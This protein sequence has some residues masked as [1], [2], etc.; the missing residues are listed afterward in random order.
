MSSVFLQG[1]VQCLQYDA[2]KIVSGSWD[3]TCIVSV[4][5]YLKIDQAFFLWYI[6]LQVWDVVHFEALTELRGHTGCVS[7]LQFNQDIL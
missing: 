5:S 4:V 2:Y 7:C 6:I 1:S 3:T